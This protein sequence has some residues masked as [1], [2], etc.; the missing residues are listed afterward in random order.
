MAK[1]GRKPRIMEE[2]VEVKG[3]PTTPEEARARI[4]EIDKRLAELDMKAA[5]CEEQE[6]VYREQNKIEFF[7]PI[8]TVFCK[9]GTEMVFDWT[10]KKDEPGW[11]CP[12]CPEVS[13]EHPPYQKRILEFIQQNKKVIAL[14]GGSGIGKTTLGAVIVISACLGIK[15][16]DRETFPPPLDKPPVKARIICTDWE[17]H[18]EKVI[19]PKLKEFIPLGEL[20]GEPKKNNLGIE[21]FFPFRNNSSIELITNKQATIDHSGWE[22]QIIWGDEPFDRDKFIE[23]LR[24][25]R[26]PPEKGGMGVFLMTMTAV[27]ASWVLDDVINSTDPDYIHVANIHQDANPFLTEQYKR[28]YRAPLKET[29]KI[30]RIYGGF[31]NLVGLIWPDLNPDIHVVDDFKVPT[32]WPVVPL[33]DWHTNKPIAVSFY[34][35]DQRDFHYVVDEIWQNGSAEEIGDEIIRRKRLNPW[36]IEEAFIDPLSKGDTGYVKNMG[37]EVVKDSFNRLK[38]KLWD[39]GIDLKVAT[40]DKNSGISNIGDMLKGLNGMPS[41]FF[42]RSLVNKFKEEGTIW[43]MQRWVYDEKTQKPKDE[44]DHFCENLYRMTLTGVKYTPGENEK[45]QEVAESDFNVYTGDRQ[46]EADNRESAWR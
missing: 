45:R 36:R 8:R 1:R 29:E 46:T 20:N 19:V 40:K 25:L 24:G 37:V 13:F 35:V 27:N 2:V 28:I 44:N 5:E 42:F 9:C 4:E 14:I 11:W 21:A 23:N 18:A 43:E 26:N 15:P 17:K 33:I 10:K 22:G 34:A 31:V 7:K 32:D 41:L 39:E 6:R 30:A 3:K 12:K 38:D 16:W